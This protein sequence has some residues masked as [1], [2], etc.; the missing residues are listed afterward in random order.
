[1][2]TTTYGILVFFSPLNPQVFSPP[3]DSGLQ[4]TRSGVD[5]TWALQ[6]RVRKLGT[7]AAKIY[8]PP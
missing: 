7:A 5:Q 4:Q 8:S 6:G 3:S 1:M 2:E